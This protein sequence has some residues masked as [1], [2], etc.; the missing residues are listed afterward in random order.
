MWSQGCKASPYYFTKTP[1]APAQTSHTLL[2]SVTLTQNCYIVSTNIVLL[3]NYT[4]TLV[5]E[6]YLNVVSG[7]SCEAAGFTK[8]TK[9]RLIGTWGQT[10]RRTWLFN[11]QQEITSFK[12]LIP[13]NYYIIISSSRS[14]VVFIAVMIIY[15]WFIIVIII[16]EIHIFLF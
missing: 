12:Y 15:Y 6:C 16:I 11:H 9:I 14:I 1:L 10:R 2:F 7:D 8:Q 4:H 3:L 13:I 5:F